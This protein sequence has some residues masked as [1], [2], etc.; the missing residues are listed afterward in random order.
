MAPENRRGLGAALWSAPSLLLCV[1][2][3]GWSGNFVVG[4]MVGATVPPVALAFCR[5]L[6]AVV[7]L[8]PFGWRQLR[9]DLPLLRA[10]A[11][12]I[13]VLA[14]SGITVFNTFVY[15][16]LGTTPVVT[17]VLL[18]SVVP[19]FILVFAAV[20]FRERP[21]LTQ[22][23]G[24]T[25]SL[26]GVWIVVTGGQMVPTRSGPATGL[27]ALWILAAVISYALYTAVLRLAPPVHPISL[28]LATFGVGLAFL[29]PFALGEFLLGARMP[30]TPGTVAAVLYVALVPSILSYFCWNRG[31]QLL[32]GARAGQYIHL[33]PVFGAVL[34]FV[35]LGEALRPYHLLAGAVI[36]AGIILAGRRPRIP[37]PVS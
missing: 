6:V 37:A 11:P 14:V 12:L 30:P 2:V 31:V 36:G 18:Q 17:G 9:T 25:L 23:A 22:V 19:V 1:A 28:L 15:I 16:G 24:L 4:R 29:A 27:G 32:G 5:W 10:Q 8:L 21:G 20:L 13:G 3:L 7:V 33:M 35:V 26:L 34:A